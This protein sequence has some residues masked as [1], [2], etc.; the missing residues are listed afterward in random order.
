ME[1]YSPIFHV[2]NL[3]FSVYVF[4]ILLGCKDLN[5]DP[6]QSLA[7]RDVGYYGDKLDSII[8]YS[9]D[10]SA[11]AKSIIFLDSLIQQPGMSTIEGKKIILNLE[12][13]YAKNFN[14]Y[15]RIFDFMNTNIRLIEAGQINNEELYFRLHLSRG[16]CYMMMDKYKEAYDD[17]MK[18]KPIWETSGP[19]DCD[20]HHFL[21]RLGLIS[22]RQERYADSREHFKNSLSIIETSCDTSRYGVFSKKQEVIN[23]IGLSFLMEDKTDSALYYFNKAFHY[24]QHQDLNNVFQNNYQKLAAAVTLKNIGNTYLKLNDYENANHFLHEAADTILKYQTNKR[25][26][27]SIL[28]RLNELNLLRSDFDAFER[29]ENEIQRLLPFIEN[30]TSLK[31]YYG[32][33][34]QYYSKTSNSEKALGAALKM[35]W[36]TAKEAELEKQLANNSFEWYSQM[37]ENKELAN[38]LS[39][40]AKLYQRYLLTVFGFFVLVVLVTIYVLFIYRKLNRKNKETE[41]LNKNL[42]LTNSKLEESNIQKNR[43]LSI[44]AHDLRNP[45]GAI[46]SLSHLLKL[47]KSD[48]ERLGLIE[49][50]E[51]SS[52]NA[53]ELINEI[54]VMSSIEHATSVVQNLKIKEV[55]LEDLMYDI[56]QTHSFKAKNKNQEIKLKIKDPKLLIE[57]DTNLLRRALGNILGNAIKFSQQN[58]TINVLVSSSKYY[59]LFEI[60]D[61]GIGIPEEL[62]N[63]L[64]KSF[65]KA[66]RSGTNGEE[67]FGLGLYISKVIVEAHSGNIQFKSIKGMGTTFFVEIPIKF[68]S[69]S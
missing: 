40:N 36:Y 16:D 28:V 53:S 12:G 20:K 58:S 59:V 41:S 66:K 69:K 15:S 46:Y 54:L 43:I 56:V 51:R 26:R 34:H 33:M 61:S 60:K 68:K 19:L 44:A 21:H 32:V 11:K 62:Q 50:V 8:N 18:I 5:F 49:L 31:N 29:N 4:I 2:R 35:Q 48:K 45:V 1:N 64:F 55:T 13:M 7:L 57:V 14:D 39:Q 22:Y 63:E 9:A 6:S 52:K 37:Y 42:A 10:Q 24:I 17:Y 30:A 25:D 38:L 67:P 3:L 65:S 47:E 23:N 27:L